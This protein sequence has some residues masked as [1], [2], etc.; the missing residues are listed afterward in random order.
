MHAELHTALRKLRSAVEFIDT[1]RADTKTD[2]YATGAWRDAREGLEEAA[3]EV[4]A[5]IPTTPDTA[6]SLLAEAFELAKL[7]DIDE[8]TD[9]GLG[10]GDWYKRT[11]ER[12]AS[13]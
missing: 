5:A 6:V 4:T 8:T 7:G 3:R 11:Q 1:I 10:W 12:L 2:A 9:D 13:E